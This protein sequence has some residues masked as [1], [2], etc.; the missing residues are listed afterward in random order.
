MI[1]R[2]GVKTFWALYF[3]LYLALAF[4]AGFTIVTLWTNDEPMPCSIH[5]KGRPRG[6]IPIPSRPKDE[7]R[8]QELIHSCLPNG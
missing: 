7:I 5:P 6:R 2:I 3:A 4:V 8:K 1:R